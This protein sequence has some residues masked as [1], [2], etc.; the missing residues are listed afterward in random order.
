MATIEAICCFEF[1][2]EDVAAPMDA[3]CEEL[4]EGFVRYL[5][6]EVLL[7]AFLFLAEFRGFTLHAEMEAVLFEKA[8]E[9][10]YLVGGEDVVDKLVVTEQLEEGMV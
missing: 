7:D 4:L 5:V 8:F 10:L 6:Y 3:C 2:V 9:M 1:V